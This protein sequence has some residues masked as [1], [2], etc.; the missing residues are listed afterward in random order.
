MTVWFWLAPLVFFM[1]SSASAPEPPGLLMGTKG[2][3]AMPFFSMTLCISRAILSAP[4]PLPAMM[5]KS[6]GFCGS[7][8]IATLETAS[9]PATASAPARLPAMRF[10][11]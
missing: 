6:T 5:M 4:P 1:W 11:E 8:A 7:H 9:E 3:D 10:L 2:L